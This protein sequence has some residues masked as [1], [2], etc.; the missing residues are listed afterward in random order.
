MQKPLDNS[1]ERPVSEEI[2]EIEPE[3]ILVPASNGSPS[4]FPEVR[5]FVGDSYSPQKSGTSESGPQFSTSSTPFSPTFR[6]NEELLKEGEKK[7]RNE[8]QKIRRNSWRTPLI[9]FLFTLYTTW[10]AGESQ[11]GE[12]GYLFCIAIM[13]ILIAHEMGHYLQ[14]LRYGVPSSLPHFIPMPYGPFG[15]MGA[16]IRMHDQ[17]PNIKALFDIG[18]SGPLAGLVPTLIFSWIGI[19]L[20]H[21]TPQAAV[22]WVPPL[23]FQWFTYLNFGPLPVDVALD[24]HPFAFAG[25]FGL[26]ITSLNL[27]PIGQLDGGHILYG[28]FGK[29]ARIYSL[30]IF[31]LIIVSVIFYRLWFWM[32]MILLL[33]W[34]GAVHPPTRND[35]VKIGMIRKTLGV[36]TLLFLFVGFA[37]V[38]IREELYMP[39]IPP[40][41][42]ALKDWRKQEFRTT[43]KPVA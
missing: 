36:L 38:P 22:V 4:D 27:M 6:W 24:L 8:S 5:E 7:D 12:K 11:F 31:N 16:F 42:Y 21:I 25:W 18:I 2:I 1:S 33:A 29:R 15:T 13:V 35:R 14:A 9:L 3:D 32:L 37:P 10:R 43:Y 19:S 41:I 20:S 34:M 39:E 17:V 40:E 28:L 23:I 30:V 26:L